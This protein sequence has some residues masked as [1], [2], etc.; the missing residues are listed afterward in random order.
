MDKDRTIFI[1]QDNFYIGLGW[2]S[3]HDMDAS[4]VIYDKNGVKLDYC[5]FKNFNYPRNVEKEKVA[6]SHS[7]DKR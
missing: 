3:D 2:D 4:V 6:I 7:G 1:N 5:Y